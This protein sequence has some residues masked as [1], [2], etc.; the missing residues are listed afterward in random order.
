MKG[1]EYKQ[2]NDTK[3]VL[4]HIHFV[5]GDVYQVCLNKAELQYK[6]NYNSAYVKILSDLTNWSEK[7]G[8][9]NLVLME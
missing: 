5:Y 2:Q 1:K 4:L 3:A 8:Y 9:N 6:N 7:N